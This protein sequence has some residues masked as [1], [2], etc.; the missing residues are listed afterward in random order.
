MRRA[1]FVLTV[2]LSGCGEKA[3][4]PAEPT[5]QKP[6]WQL[7]TPEACQAAIARMR[8]V[9][10]EGLDPDPSVDQDDCMNLPAGLVACLATI[11]NRDDAEACADKA[12][13]TRPPPKP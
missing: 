6:D 8:T 9:M 11:N 13:E 7:P 10:P 12:K 3:P 5:P 1:A 4:P 2:A